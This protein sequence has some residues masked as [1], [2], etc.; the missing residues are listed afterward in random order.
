MSNQ[1]DRRGFMKSGAAAVAAWAAAGRPSFAAEASQAKAQPMERVRVGLVGVGSRGTWLLSLLLGV[2]GVEVRGLRHHPGACCQG[3]GKGGRGR[4]GETQWILAGETDFRAAFAKRRRWTWWSM[5]PG[6]GSGTCRSPWRRCRPAR[7]GHRSPRRGDDRGLLARVGRDR[8]E[9]AEI[10]RD[11]G[12]LL[13]FPRGDAGPQHAAQGCSESFATARRATSAT[14]GPARRGARP[15]EDK[16]RTANSYPT[17]P[18][19]PVAQWMDINRG[20]RFDYLVSMSADA[21]GA[22][23]TPTSTRA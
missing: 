22:T 19:G 12:E 14:P 23:A 4:P 7:R 10:L 2:E 17:H 8:G 20:N 18:I 11:A 16:V 1:F 6:P 3:P 15:R 21:T 9:D 13:L 5:Q